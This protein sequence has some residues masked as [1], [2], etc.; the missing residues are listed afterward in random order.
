MIEQVSLPRTL[1]ALLAHVGHRSAIFRAKVAKCL[2]AAVIAK[3]SEMPATKEFD[4]FKCCLPKLLQDSA[5]D[6]RAY[7]RE[8]VRLLVLRNLSSRAELEI[9]IGADLLDKILREGSIAHTLSPTVNNRAASAAPR[10]ADF[11]LAAASPARPGRVSR[12]SS[13]GGLES[14]AGRGPFTPTRNESRDFADWSSEDVSIT[15]PN[16]GRTQRATASRLHNPSTRHSSAGQHR[17]EA[18][19]GGYLEFDRS[20]SGGGDSHDLAHLVESAEQ[21]SVQLDLHI[22]SPARGAAT[23]PRVSRTVSADNRPIKGYASLEGKSRGIAGGASPSSA[24]SSYAKRAI[25]QDP[26]LSCLQEI[27]ANT[28]VNSWTERKTALDRVTSLIIKHYDTLKDANKLGG[29]VDAL[30]SRL[31]DGSV[32]VCVDQPLLSLHEFNFIN[33]CISL[34]HLYARCICIRWSAWKGFTKKSLWYCST[35]YCKSSY[36]LFSAPLHLPTSK[37]PYQHIIYHRKCN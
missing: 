3:G 4:S 8:T 22:A 7:S 2:Y 15:T 33:L 27:V 37:A 29:C 17:G 23:L 11:G 6:T 30:L 35:I 21:L 18:G 32:K 31:E 24:L 26:E 5:P 28:T 25:D 36:L 20:S 10:S 12:I 16:K 19:E 14:P 9:P 34:T 13:G 1:S